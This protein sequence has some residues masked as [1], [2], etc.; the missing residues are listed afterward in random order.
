MQQE[1]TASQEECVLHT[2]K[3]SQ[4]EEA[5]S[6]VQSE[7][8]ICM[9]QKALEQLVAALKEE[10]E[11]S[12]KRADEMQSL[13]A[14]L[15]EDVQ[16]AVREK[17]SAEEVAKSLQAHLEQ[18]ESE[19]RHRQDEL[20]EAAKAFNDAKKETR[21]LHLELEAKIALQT[22]KTE[23]E[24]YAK[25][26][27]EELNAAQEE[28]EMWQQKLSSGEEK[29]AFAR[30]LF[31][32]AIASEES[33]ETELKE[34][35]QEAVGEQRLA[36][37]AV[38]SLQTRFKG[39]DEQHALQEARL[40]AKA[41]EIEKAAKAATHAEEEAKKLRSEKQ[42]TFFACFLLRRG[43]PFAWLFPHLLCS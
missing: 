42:G 3:A 38:K 8:A 11:E 29:M 10:L 15:K 37:E 28:N 5:L 18:K 22:E 35:V 26:M 13:E 27:Q 6:Q 12:R 2:E 33:R 7:H 30:S 41:D 20:E 24:E 36:E 16:E 14:E 32:K 39:E 43:W 34:E 19:L 40:Q 31:Q 1:L 21:K 4:L 17:S 23:L 25:L 9:S